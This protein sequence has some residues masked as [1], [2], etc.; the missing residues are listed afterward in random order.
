MSNPE[1]IIRKYSD[2]RLYDTGASKYVKLDDIAGMVRD[3]LNVRVVDGRTGKDLTHLIF[4][5]IIVENAREQE[6]ALPL[7]LLTQLVRASDKATHDFLTWY[8]NNTLDLYQKAQ[9][10]VHSRLS[11]AKSAVA[12]PLEFVRNLLA[13]HSLRSQ[14]PPVE[15]EEL[16]KLR[17]RVEEL[18]TR[19]RRR[20]KGGRTGT[21]RKRRTR[22]ER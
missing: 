5:Q 8:L 15:A 4:T 16:E 3:G 1:V 10:T 6:I 20:D 9:E 18:Q 7:Q 17:D 21:K 2:R 22:R 19:L 13:G 11:T 12:S 14:G